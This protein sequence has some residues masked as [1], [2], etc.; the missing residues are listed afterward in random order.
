MCV[1]R[2]IWVPRT[3]EDRSQGKG[4]YSGVGRTL[5]RSAIVRLSTIGRRTPVGGL[6]EALSVCRQLFF[7]TL[8]V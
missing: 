7:S 5:G 4:T 6:V 2:S 3:T 1:G 8:V